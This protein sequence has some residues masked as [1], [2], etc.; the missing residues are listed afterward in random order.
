MPRFRRMSYREAQAK[1]DAMEPPEDDLPEDDEDEFY[2]EDEEF[3]FTD[4][5]R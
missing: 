5:P 3:E 2:P 4:G 1:Y